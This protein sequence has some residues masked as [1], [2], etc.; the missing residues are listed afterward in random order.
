MI[1]RRPPSQ[2]G[3]GVEEDIGKTLNLK[4]EDMGQSQSHHL[5]AIRTW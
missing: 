1:A 4:Y 5:Q 2:V 3:K